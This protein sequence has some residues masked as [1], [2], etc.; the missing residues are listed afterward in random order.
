[1]IC[2]PGTPDVADRLVIE[3]TSTTV[4]PNPLLAT[5]PTDTTTAPV[6]APLDTWTRLGSCLRPHPRREGSS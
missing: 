4:N 5:P 6:V 3:G 1:V 2:A